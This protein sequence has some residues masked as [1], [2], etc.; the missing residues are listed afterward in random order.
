MSENKFI[1]KLKGEP[2]PKSVVEIQ[3][4]RLVAPFKSSP[5]GHIADRDSSIVVAKGAQNWAVNQG[6][7][8]P[9]A[10]DYIGTESN[11]TATSRVSGAGLWL[12]ATYTFPATGDETNPVSAIIAP[13]AKWVLTL[14]GDSLITQNGSVITLTMLVKIGAT[15]LTTK[16]F[17]IREC[18]SQFSQRLAIDFSESEQKVIKAHG[19]SPLT[20]QVLCDDEGAS[21]TI[22]S[23]MTH[24]TLLQRKIDADLVATDNVLLPEFIENLLEGYII[25]ADY[26]SNYDYIEQV[27]EGGKVMPKFTRNGDNM[28]FSG[29]IKPVT[30]VYS[31]TEID[32][33]VAVINTAIDANAEAIQKTREDYI[34]ADS[35]IHQILN[36]HAGELTTLH[37]DV[38][39]LGDQVAGI[40]SKIP[41]SA[42]AENPLVT[43]SEISSV[44]KFKGSVATYNDLPTGATVGDV[45]NVTDTGANYAWDGSAWDKLSETVDLSSYATTAYVNAREQDI[46]DDYVQA[47]SELQ[48]QINAHATAITNLDGEVDTINGKIPTSASTTNLLATIADLDA[49]E[50]DVRDDY[51]A[52]DADLQTQINGQANTITGI[53]DD[54]TEINGKI[55][56][57]ASSTNKLIS[58]SEL[59]AESQDIR[60][61]YM[62][63][64]SELQTQIN[65]LSSAVA[66]NQSNISG[67]R[68][69]VGDLENQVTS[70]H[71]DIT[72]HIADTSNPHNVTKTQVGLGNVDNTSDANKPVSTAQQAALN[73]K[74]DKSTTYSKTEVDDLLAPK[75]DSET[76]ED[77]YATITNL[78]AHIS[79]TSNP[80]SVTKTQVGLGNVDNTSDLNKPVSTAQQAAIN[81]AKQDV[82]SGY[83]TADGELQQQINGQ[84]TAISTNASNITA[85][86]TR[87]GTNE[88]NIALL[89]SDVSTINTDVATAKTDITNLKSSVNSQAGLI[90]GLQDDVS[91]KVDKNQGTANAGKILSVGSDGQVTLTSAP[92]GGLTAVAHDSTLTGTGT[93]SSPLGIASTVLAEI[94][95][96]ADQTTVETLSGVVSQNT[97]N[98]GTLRTDV[99]DLG[100]QVSSIEGKIP[101]SASSTNLL[102]TKSEIPTVPTNVSA[103]NNDSG[104]ITSSALTPYA[105]TQALNDGLATKAD[106]DY[107]DEQLNN[108]ADLEIFNAIYPVGSIYI[109]TQATCPMAI[110]IPNST[111]ELLEA[112]RALWTGNGSN[113]NTTIA[114]GLPNITG[115]QGA[116]GEFSKQSPSGAI[117]FTASGRGIVGDH[118]GKDAYNINFDAS[119]SNSI[120]G[121]S[122]TVQPPAY[123]VNVWRR[124]A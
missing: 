17:K 84:A 90:Q 25:P 36:N 19:G 87:V 117:Y 56:S 44:Y 62:A 50:Q 37:N 61:D 102:A 53:Q 13:S 104:Y 120:Y 51:M 32:D 28:S 66:T 41:E 86:T 59:T 105:T 89:D 6:Q 112:G 45:Y 3:N 47:D 115:H 16:Q 69:D 15:H 118:S 73:L 74:A 65:G 30:D 107:V 75:L 76:A 52:A 101:A 95:D 68:T 42:S 43:R 34:E 124:T 96:K 33:K 35:E 60:S 82:I 64:D 77:T 71:N 12:N 108:K 109:G 80:H 46:R 113:G 26:F 116:G 14:C 40:E 18:A 85:L 23:G 103:F 88:T 97:T 31:K 39:N 21:A 24:L 93:D 2:T 123:V 92:G 122:G 57:S 38:D 81:T 54:I 55:S 72:A 8:V 114:A 100:D 63:A 99:D 4:D 10:D 83:T 22:Y 58:A 5:M 119:R 94:A 98:I 91:G 11:L 70:N 111:W 29:W 110:A 9:V 27:E 20:V 106:T 67:L 7:L 121:N 79:N 49:T 78:N 48:Q 1:A